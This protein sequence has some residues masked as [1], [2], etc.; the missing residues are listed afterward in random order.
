[1]AGTEGMAAEILCRTKTWRQIASSE[2]EG[3]ELQESGNLSQVDTRCPSKQ[4]QKKTLLN[5]S[6]NEVFQRLTV[7]VVMRISLSAHG[8]G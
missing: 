6:G 3:Q 4:C 5:R 7:A 1:M 8:R 2:G